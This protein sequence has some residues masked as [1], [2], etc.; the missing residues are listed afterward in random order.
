[1]ADLHAL[2]AAEAARRIRAG[3]LSPLDLV[4]ACLARIDATEPIVGAWVHVDRDAA[5]R[6]AR[7]RE[8]EA[9]E[10]RLLGP[11][12]G[13]PV[14]LKDIFDTAGLVTTAG[15]GAF[16]HRRAPAD[17]T[18][19]ARLRA[20]GAVL[21]G[22]VTTTAFAFMDPSKTR[23][24]WNAEHTP[25]GSSSGSA[26]SVAARMT[27]L[28]LGSQTVG[29]TLRP[30][31]YC[32][33]VGL[34]PSHGRI[35]T[36]GIVPLASSLDH[37]GIFGR[38]VEDV[39]LT[40]SAL[41]GFDPS[42]PLSSD[43]PVDDYAG[44]VRD[45]EAPRLGVLSSLVD[46]AGPEVAR[47][48]AETARRLERAGAHVRDVSLPPSFA[49]IHEVGTIVL[50]AEAAGHHRE[51]FA[52]HAALY[53]PRTRAALEEGGRIAAVDYLAAQRERRRFHQ[54]AGDLASRWDALLTPVAS[55][56]APRGLD[57]TGDPYFCSPWSS[58]GLPAVALP[59]G[60]G[61]GGLPLSIQ[62][63][64]GPFA[65]ARLL[66]AAAWCERVISFEAAPPL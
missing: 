13:V 48:L 60:M 12:H 38:A 58:A 19:T 57:S 27:P 65:E 61:E 35:G 1:M 30:A 17:A 15:A 45:P 4:A 63:V 11:L 2:G 28:A 44:A 23:N 16:A 26:A 25:G 21:L 9:R 53:P 32:G 34:K 37:V 52:R 18:A 64:G 47:H 41:A 31:G 43:A 40:L 42:D 20:A 50:R 66:A 56:S 39:A 8:I 24:P 22:K 5:L 3:E 51:L 59:S 29:S 54:E 14:A 6:S 36:T 33:V 62:L 10:G 46:R 7:E 55:S 49:R